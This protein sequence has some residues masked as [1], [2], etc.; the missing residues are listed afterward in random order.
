MSHLFIRGGKPLQGTIKVHG[1]KN[2]VLPVIAASI[3]GASGTSVIHEVPELDDVN[4]M[5]QVLQALGIEVSRQNDTLLIAAEQLTCTE[6]PL[7]LVNRMRASILVMGPLLA[8][9]GQVRVGLPGGCAIGS[10]PIDQHL[11]GFEAMGAQILYGEHYVEARIRNNRDRLQGARIYLDI[12][13]VGATENIMMAAVLA[14][15]TTLIENAAR[16]PEIVDISNMLNAM[17]G[18]VRGAGTATIRIEGV[19]S[20]HAVHHT[21]IPDRIEAGTYLIAGA[22]T[23]GNVF[24]E[25]A[26]SDH[27]MPLLAK[28]REMG[29]SIDVREQGIAI[30]V[31]QPL[32]SCDVKTLPYPGFPTDL[33]SQMMA[34]LTTVTGDSVITETIFENRYM[35]V[36]ELQK[37][38]AQITV[39][40]RQAIVHGGRSL[41]A[42]QATATDLRAGAAIILAALAAD[43][44]SEITG[45][46]HIDRGYVDIVGKLKGVGA[47]IERQ[48]SLTVKTAGITHQAPSI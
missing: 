18:H 10:R 43:G 32:R 46:H 31:N 22:I 4:T 42:A 28:L 13:S 38:N 34:L 16:E 6:A 33:Q 41:Q 45:L 37:F 48:Q 1:A 15:G 8:R 21:V 11:K 27:L 30:E 3:L 36:A 29:A 5:I 25:G 39:D 26:I 40:G 14:Q 7:E 24:V 20:L 23:S 19:P 44:E 47:T 17:G 12:P 2:A 35:H 9:F